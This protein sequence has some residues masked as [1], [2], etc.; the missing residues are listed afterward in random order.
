MSRCTLRV[1]LYM[2][3]AR[4]CCASTNVSSSETLRS[5][6]P[7]PLNKNLLQ[8]CE[9][10]HAGSAA[11]CNLSTSGWLLQRSCSAQCNGCA[12]EGWCDVPGI[13]NVSVIHKLL[14]LRQHCSK[15][16]NMCSIAELV[17]ASARVSC[18][19]RSHHSPASNATSR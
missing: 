17:F 1:A 13:S 18:L 15:G 11:G 16:K 6:L 7:L 12:G 3:V 2:P 10:Q 19:Y 4:Q 14:V 8:A 5:S 9:V